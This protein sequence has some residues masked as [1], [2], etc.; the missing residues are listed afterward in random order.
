MNISFE[1][2][3]YGIIFVAV[4]MMIEGIYLLVFGKSITKRFLNSSVRR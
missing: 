3:L 4:L 1:P 2:L